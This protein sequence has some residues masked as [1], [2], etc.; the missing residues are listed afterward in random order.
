MLSLRFRVDRV[1]HSLVHSLIH[2]SITW[3]A[4]EP[5]GA[6]RSASA[7]AFAYAHARAVAACMYARIRHAFPTCKHML[8][9]RGKSRKGKTPRQTFFLLLSLLLIFSPSPL[10]VYYGR[11]RK[12]SDKPDRLHMAMR[13]VQETVFLDLSE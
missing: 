13:F 9:V 6:A 1:V 8:S 11:L 12:N 4:C 10:L 2:V 3:L 5:H 7:F